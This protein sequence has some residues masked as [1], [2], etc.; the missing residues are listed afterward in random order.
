MEYV[1]FGNAGI[2]VSRLCFGSMN[3]QNHP[4]G[5]AGSTRMVHEALGAGV[6][7]FDT[8]DGYGKG[9]SE[10]LLGRALRDRRDH[11]VIASKL[12]VP[13]YEGDPNGRGTGRYH[14]IR[15]CEDSL[16]R[17]GT[18]RIDLYQLHHPDDQSPVEE[19]IKTMDTLIGQGKVRYFGVS[20]HYAW[21]MAHMLGVAALHDWEPIVSIQ[22]CYNVLDRVVENETAPFCRRFNIA[23]ML[24]SPLGGGLLGGRLKRGQKPPKDAQVNAY[25]GVE[26]VLRIP[27][28]RA[29][30]RL[31]DVLEEMERIAKRYNLTVAQLAIKW[32]LAQ[33]WATTPILGG[34]RSEHFAPMYKVFD[35]KVEDEDMKRISEE[36]ERFRY[37]PFRNQGV[38]QG[39][40]EQRNWW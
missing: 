11:V 28:E 4:D 40:A 14:M 19:T 21:Q 7:F 27:E 36:S 8:A 30:D 17:L 32:I 22:C 37:Q 34:K 1:K 3:I 12:W 38:V 13:M 31:F 18:D 20:N 26:K 25:G 39:A 35:T 16:R 33:D 10:E 23:S 2:V 24:Y 29:E 5:E 6:N 15:A 9:R